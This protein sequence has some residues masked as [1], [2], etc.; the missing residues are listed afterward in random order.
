MNLPLSKEL[1]SHLIPV[2]VE[3]RTGTVSPYLEVMLYRRNYSL[4]TKH[5]NY[6]Y[7][8]L[9]RV[10]DN[11]FQKINLTLF[12]FRNI[13]VLGMGAGSVITLLREKYDL[14]CSITAIEKDKVVI[15]LAKQY[16][17]IDRHKNLE[18]INDDAYNFVF[19][20]E[21]KYDLIISD[22]FI[23]ADVPG[24]FASE[25]YLQQLKQ[26]SCTNSCIIYN[27]MTEKKRHKDEFKALTLSFEAI[28]PGTEIHRIVIA[29]KENSI[30]CFNNIHTALKNKCI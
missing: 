30:L 15:E 12:D 22:I 4:N 10:F 16:F 3:T 9:H 20:T 7:G 2:I 5:V 14:K 24:I 26:I 21:N 28:F 11:L 18:V 25:E 6:S 1:L 17:N 8:G 19:R 13:L 27:K 29:G 23:D